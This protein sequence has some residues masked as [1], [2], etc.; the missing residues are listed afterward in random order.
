MFTGYSWLNTK[1]D[2]GQKWHGFLVV[3]LSAWP[4]I[5]VCCGYKLAGTAVITTA[6]A[7][8]TACMVHGGSTLLAFLQAWLFLASLLAYRN[9]E[10][11]SAC[12]EF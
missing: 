1:T 5:S 12:H 2:L 6:A 10:T 9:A 8:C 4:I 7:T 3:L 11:T